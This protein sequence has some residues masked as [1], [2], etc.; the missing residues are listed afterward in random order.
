MSKYN[1]LRGVATLPLMAGALSLGG[2]ALTTNEQDT[3][4]TFDTL[5]LVQKEHLLND[6]TLPCCHLSIKLHPPMAGVDS[7]AM[8]YLTPLYIT[9][10]LGEAYS[11]MPLDEALAVYAADYITEYKELEIDIQSYNMIGAYMNYELSVTDSV[12][13]N[14]E[15]IYSYGATSYSY[16]GGAHGLQTTIHYNVDL[17]RMQPIATTDLFQEGT[18]EYVGDLIRN[19]LVEMKREDIAFFEMQE[20]VVTENFFVGD[21]GI[22]WVYNPYDIAS[23]AMGSSYVLVTYSELQPYLQLQSPIMAIAKRAIKRQETTIQNK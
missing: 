8:S 2:C 22:T 23:Y 11:L 7:V 3:A 10:I 19:S 14:K 16:M 12:L 18:A 9:G 13:Y 17:N 4:L 15:G 21:N 5:Q 6:T 1:I 20:V